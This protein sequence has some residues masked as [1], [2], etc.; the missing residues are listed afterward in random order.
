MPRPRSAGRLVLAVLAAGA[1]FGSVH[2]FATSFGTGS[3]GL[4][5]GS[6]PVTSCGAGLTVSYSTAFDPGIDESAITD[7]DVSNIP[8]GCLRRNLVLSFYGSGGRAEGAP[9][10]ETLPSSGATV[11]IA[12]DPSTNTIDAAALTG[13]SVV[14]S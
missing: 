1:V 9:I 7:I 2:G 10:R 8:A 6:E 12:V 5:A 11:E 14:V 3:G 4:G 13:V